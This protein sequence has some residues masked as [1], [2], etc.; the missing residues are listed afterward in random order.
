[1]CA[2]ERSCER[3]RC[4]VISSLHGGSIR[5]RFRQSSAP[6]VHG[7]PTVMRRSMSTAYATR[8][9]CSAVPHSR[10]G[11]A[12]RKRSG[13]AFGAR[14]NSS[15]GRSISKM[16]AAV[17]GYAHHATSSASLTCTAK[18][19][20]RP[21]SPLVKCARAKYVSAQSRTSAIGVSVAKKSFCAKLNSAMHAT[22][23]C[24]MSSWSHAS[25]SSTFEKG[26]GKLIAS[27]ASM[28][29][30]IWKSVHRILIRD[31]EITRYVRVARTV[32]IERSA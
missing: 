3:T 4:F 15:H 9:L 2:T 16:V 13:A 24:R 1:M 29:V 32:T 25:A 30:M 28:D 10:L 14:S 17:V 5:A 31:G 23:K 7:T 12:P 20:R 6:K 18:T 27:I 11:S 19:L 22:G 26:G 21:S 8:P